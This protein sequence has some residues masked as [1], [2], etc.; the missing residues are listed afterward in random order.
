MP[1]IVTHTLTHGPAPTIVGPVEQLT[2][3]HAGFA[4]N[5]LGQQ[6]TLNGSGFFDPEYRDCLVTSA[7]NL[8]RPDGP[9]RTVKISV[10]AASGQRFSLSGA[11]FAV[12]EDYSASEVAGDIAVV[13]LSAPITLWD[14][15]PLRTPPDGTFDAYLRAYNSDPGFDHH[16]PLTSSFIARATGDHLVY[17]EAAATEE[18][19]GAPV[20]SNTPRFVAGLHKGIH[21]GQLVGVRIDMDLVHELYH[22]LG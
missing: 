14:G 9:A 3:I 7:H 8:V 16:Q 15:L 20:I 12:L 21:G 11:M 19:S 18:M 17:N 2:R 4:P 10:H 6:I 22:A 1:T 13:L 5:V